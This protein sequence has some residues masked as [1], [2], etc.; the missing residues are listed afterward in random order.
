VSAPRLSDYP[1]IHP[2]DLKGGGLSPKEPPVDLFYPGRAYSDSIIKGYATVGIELDEKGNAVDYLLIA[3][4]EK[5]FGDALMRNAKRTIYSPLLYKGVA[6]PSRLNFGYQFRPQFNMTMTSFDAITH[7]QLEI[8]G[9]RPP[10]KF[11]PVAE[12]KLDNRLEYVRQAVPNFPA[13]Y[14]PTGGKED[15]VMVTLYV[16]EQGNV[17]VPRVESA[18]SPLLIGNA[19][20]AVHYWQFK[21]PTVKGQPVLVYAAFALNFA[22]A[23]K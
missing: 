20:K 2:K 15:W 4:T 22:Q 16:D 6:V 9:G 14:T 3:Y 21:P 1:M 19:I 8:Q 5:Y 7:R 17:R 12:E 18:S 13:G 11:Q 10:F 23:G